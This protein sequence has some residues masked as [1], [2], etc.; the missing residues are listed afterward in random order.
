[1]TDIMRL[2]KVK[3][4]GQTVTYSQGFFGGLLRRDLPLDRNQLRQRFKGEIPD[5]I[6][7][8]IREVVHDEFREDVDKDL[9]NRKIQ[10]KRLAR[11]EEL[12]DMQVK[13]ALQRLQKKFGQS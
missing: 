3:E 1:M 12:D 2:R 9:R 7:I 4:Y 6:E 5:E 8:E 10:E 11:Q 13:G